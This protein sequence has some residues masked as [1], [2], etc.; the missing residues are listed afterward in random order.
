[1]SHTEPDQK[2]ST[3]VPIRCSVCGEPTHKTLDSIL[4][5]GAL[6]CVCGAR[7]ELDIEQFTREIRRSAA[8]VNEFGEDG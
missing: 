1:M 4:A 3:T 7:T 6:L 5:S 2:R 8:D